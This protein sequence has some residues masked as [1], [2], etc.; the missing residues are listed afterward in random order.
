MRRAHHASDRHQVADEIEV[1][2]AVKRGID[3]IARIG[4]Q[5]G[6]AIGR[7]GGDR[8]GSDI[9]AA[10]WPVLDDERL[11]ESIRQPLADQAAG[12]IGGAAR[13]EGDDHAHRPRRVVL[14][15]GAARYGRRCGE[16]CGELQ[17]LS[18]GIGHGRFSGIDER[19][20]RQAGR[21][22]CEWTSSFEARHR[23]DLAGCRLRMAQA[24]PLHARKH[25]LNEKR[26]L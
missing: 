7:R 13:R 26:H 25:L 9:G 24:G 18:A 6:V 11:A 17:E 12:D 10:S 23:R 5:Q 16:G 19:R 15:P 3:R 21:L 2:L 20:E 14:R 8:L 22:L 4:H 1:E